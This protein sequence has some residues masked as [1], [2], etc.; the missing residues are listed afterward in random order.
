MGSRQLGLLTFN[1]RSSEASALKQTSKGK[2]RS[3]PPSQPF[4]ALD[5]SPCVDPGLAR[6]LR[7]LHL[8]FLAHYATHHTQE[9][10]LF[11]GKYFNFKTFSSCGFKGK[12]GARVGVFGKQTRLLSHLIF[13]IKVQYLFSRNKRLLVEKSNT[14]VSRFT[15]QMPVL[16]LMLSL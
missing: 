10:Y 2:E 4:K 14:S 6:K 12:K 3:V 9:V 1:L 7:H 5:V 8:S 15:V 13:R 11:I 16:H